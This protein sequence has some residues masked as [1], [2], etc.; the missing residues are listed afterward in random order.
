MIEENT[1]ATENIEK[2][3]IYIHFQRKDKNNHTN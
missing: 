2:K 3:N 1:I